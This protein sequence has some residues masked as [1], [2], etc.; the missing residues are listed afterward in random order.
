[1]SL[2]KSFFLAFRKSV[3]FLRNCHWRSLF[4][5][6][7]VI[8]LLCWKQRDYVIV[9][10]HEITLINCCSRHSACRGQV[11]AI[12]F[13]I[14]VQN[15]EGTLKVARTQFVVRKHWNVH[16]SRVGK[17]F[18]R[19]KVLNFNSFYRLRNAVQF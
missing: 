7:G 4:P 17:I 10:K 11:E 12:I 19:T 18:L 14:F 5:V 1:M 13:V 16:A 15:P 2:V 6:L 9:Y 8:K 3:C